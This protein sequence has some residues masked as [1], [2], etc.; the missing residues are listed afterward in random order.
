MPDPE[1]REFNFLPNLPKS[2][3]DDRTFEDLVQEC[4]LR[5]PRYCP[6]W[7]NHNPGDPGITLIE[8]F[9]WLVDQMLLRFN[10]VPRRNYV[11]FLELLGIRLQ[12][13]SAAHTDLTFYLTKATY[14]SPLRIPTYTEVATTRTES[15]PAVVFTTDD[16]LIIG[17]PQI[18]GLFTA[19][20]AE[21]IPTSRQFSVAL[22]RSENT[23]WDNLGEVTLFEDCNVNNCFYIV[24]APTNPTARSSVAHGTY[25]NG[26]NGQ[27]VNT[28]QDS[29]TGNILSLRFKGVIAGTTGINPDDPP[30]SWQV[31]DGED[32]QPG[33]LRELQDDRT[34]GFSFHELRQQGMNADQVGADVILHLPQKWPTTD[35]GTG[36]QGHWIRC[37]YH[38]SRETQYPY[39]RSPSIR[40]ISVS[41]IGGV[42]HASECVRVKHE[43]LGVSDGKAGQVFYLQ[44]TPLI[45][46][47]AHE[48]IQVNYPDGRV[49]D[50]QEVS[51]FGNSR[52]NSRHYMIDAQNGMVQFGPLI[53]EP[54]QLQ[55]QTRDRSHQLQPWGKQIRHLSR[56]S[57]SLDA[58]LLSA[59]S[60]SQQYQE[61]QYGQVPP[62]GAEIYMTAYR[63]GGGSRG[64][65]QKETLNVLRTA[66]PYVKRVTNYDPAQGGQEGE[67]LDEAVIRVPQVLRSSQA[68]V[69]P[70][71]FE[72]I[73]QQV[74]AVY[75]AHCPPARSER[76]DIPGLVR[77][78]IVPLPPGADPRSSDFRQAFP[79]GM[80]PDQCFKLDVLGTKTREHLNAVL[81]ERKP[82]GIQVKLDTPVYVGVKVIAEVWLEPAYNHPQTRLDIQSRLTALLYRFLNPITGGF[83]QTG[84][85][86]GR[87]LSTSDVVAY[88]QDVPEVR[89]VGAVKLFP[90]RKLASQPEWIQ[91]DIP[92]LAIAPGNVGLFCSWENHQD[93]V[94]K[95][96]HDIHLMD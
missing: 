9:S 47:D 28:I 80:D 71:D 82:L 73:A 90:I 29:I 23:Q 3:L 76:G 57:H 81:D 20:Q 17:Q 2:N 85:E 69:T 92:E 70:A 84:W 45:Q 54:N 46:C 58:P 59:D 65:V 74:G 19:R 43:L 67:R 5:I 53:R 49:E 56:S 22:Q 35:F 36:C 11:A 16:E 52:A 44:N 26:S 14:Q 30:L 77:L 55:K 66:I 37:V 15:E 8:L 25:G 41:A 33:I 72:A 1:F 87:P 63:V 38:Q 4:I 31:W 39:S 50:W 68:A 96:G 10:Q 62:L 94:S 91:S 12:P 27:S 18:Q 24:L 88:L 48:H 51:D 64:N 75:R 13:P 86:L 79:Y 78:F 61:W 40:S 83:Q 32:W 21:H 6:E 42:I 89:Y 34:K 95:F 93:N 60:E 7:T